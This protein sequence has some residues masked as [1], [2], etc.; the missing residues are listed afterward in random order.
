MHLLLNQL[1]FHDPDHSRAGTIHDSLPV[2]K[3][4]LADFN[5]SS[6]DLLEIVQD[7][8]RVERF[9]TPFK[10]DFK[11]Q[12][13]HAQTPP[14]TRINNSAICMQFTDFIS[15]TIVEC[16]ASGVL[17][18]WGEVGVVS[19]PHLILPITVDPSKPRLCHDERFLICGSGIFHLNWINFPICLGMFYLGIS[20]PPL[21]TRG[22]N[23]H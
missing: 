20:R 10:G 8:V 22:Q 5:C 21:M 11:G 1:R 9:F 6:V 19:P 18:V 16:V 17:A 15:D 13:Y 2:W 23:E 14:A 4:L 12:F 7:G 3:S